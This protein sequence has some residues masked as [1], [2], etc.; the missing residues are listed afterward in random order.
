MGFILS[1]SFLSDSSI[2]SM[3]ISQLPGMLAGFALL[4]NIPDNPL[5][6][7]VYLGSMNE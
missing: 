4:Q 7:K 1:V 5:G 2:F 3:L 6:E